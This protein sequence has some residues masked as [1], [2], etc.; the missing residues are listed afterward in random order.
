MKTVLISVTTDMSPTG[1][2]LVT[3]MLLG[4]VMS[5]EHPLQRDPPG[6]P[7]ESPCPPD[8]LRSPSEAERIPTGNH[9]ISISYKNLQIRDLDDPIRRLSDPSPSIAVY[10]HWSP[11]CQAAARVPQRKTCCEHQPATGPHCMR[12]FW[13][14]S[15]SLII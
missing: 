2:L 9:L 8:P 10:R 12:V 4:R 14:A 6:S 3:L 11:P 15:A 5:S 7:V 13:S 1:D